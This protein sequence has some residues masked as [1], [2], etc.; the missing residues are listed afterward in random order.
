M[1]MEQAVDKAVTYC[2][3]NNILS[4]F[5]T[6]HRAEVI[7]VCITEYDKQAFVNGIREEGRQEGRKEGRQEGRALTL[8]SLVNSGNLKPDI[9]AKELGISIHEF[10]IAMKEAGMNQPVSK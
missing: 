10:E 2:I 8:Y 1:R 6:K 9:A 4:E 7:D 5:L 3:N